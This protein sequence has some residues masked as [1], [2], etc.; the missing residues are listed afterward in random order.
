MLAGG[1]TVVV[2]TSGGPD[3]VALLHVLRRLQPELRLALHVAHIDHGVHR[4]A[5]AHARFVRTIARGWGLPATVRRVDVRGYA[6]RHRVTLEEAARARRYAVL[7]QVARR[8]GATH[9]ATGHTA[10]DQAET[11]LLWLIRGASADSLGGIPP[12]R[13]YDG[14]QVIRP[15]LNVWRDEILA[16]LAAER[17]RWRIDPTNRMRRMLRNRIRQDLLPRL[18]GYNASVKAALCRMAQQAA[19]DAALLDRLAADAETTVVSRSR[20]GVTIDAVGFRA[21]APALQRRVAQRALRAAGGKIRDLAFVHIERIRLMAERHR[22]GEH[23]DLPGLRARGTSTGVAIT[24][25]PNR[26]L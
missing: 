5:A 8:I 17:L 21:L 15:L 12:V 11:V 1:E 9:I 26:M 3:S 19:T 4:R 2:A 10:D 6:R 18:A 20:A 22:P 23:A 7:A 24:R 13:P 16:Y 25:V 14:L